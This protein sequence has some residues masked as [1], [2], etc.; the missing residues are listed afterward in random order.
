[1]E[2]F[3]L[4]RDYRQA[5]S[6]SEKASIKTALRAELV[7][8]FGYRQ[9]RTKLEIESLRKRLDEEAKR[10]EESEKNKEKLINDELQKNIDRIEGKSFF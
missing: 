2:I 6:E 3:A 1:M 10:L 5:T 7:K 9:Q 4:Q 8:R